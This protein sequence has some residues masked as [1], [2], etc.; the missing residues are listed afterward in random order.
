MR[1]FR[2]KGASRVRLRQL[3]STVRKQRND[4]SAHT[5]LKLQSNVMDQWDFKKWR[6]KLGIDQVVAGGSCKRELLLPRRVP[7]NHLNQMMVFRH[8]HHPMAKARDNL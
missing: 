3:P 7:E 8:A 5:C 4:G 2:S 6:K 1:Q